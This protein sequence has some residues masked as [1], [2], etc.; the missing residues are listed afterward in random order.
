MIDW[1]QDGTTLEATIGIQAARVIRA[2]ATRYLL[3]VGGVLICHGT[4]QHCQ[5]EAERLAAK[6][7]HEETQDMAEKK[8]P[9]PK[10]KAAPKTKSAPKPAAPKAP[11]KPAAKA[12]TPAKP[13]S[14]KSAPAPTP[15]A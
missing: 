1:T 2:T 15:A 12:K 8:T 13:K 5:H 3:H 7:A 14:A 9:A 11:K 6:L 10:T 4:L